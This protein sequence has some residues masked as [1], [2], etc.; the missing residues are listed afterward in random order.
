MM[1]KQNDKKPALKTLTDWVNGDWEP[2][3]QSLFVMERQ[4]WFSTHTKGKRGKKRNLSLRLANWYP[5]SVIAIITLVVLL[6]FAVSDMPQDGVVCEETMAMTGVWELGLL[7]VSATLFMTMIGVNDL[8]QKDQNG[9]TPKL[10]YQ[11][12]MNGAAMLLTLAAMTFLL[13]SL[14]GGILTGMLAAALTAYRKQPLSQ[15][16][17]YV[18]AASLLAWTVLCGFAAWMEIME[19]W[20]LEIVTSAGLEI[21]MSVFTAS[22]AYG[23]C[24]IASKRLK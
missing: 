10:E 15:F 17:G 2:K 5:V 7:G 4:N 11:S 22:A 23:A 16:H 20:T 12:V 18:Q 19:F 24:S 6:L 1:S 8:Y 3:D 13:G 14:A 9:R 21:S